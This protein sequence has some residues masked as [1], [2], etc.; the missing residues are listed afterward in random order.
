MAEPASWRNR[1]PGDLS[2]E[3]AEIRATP[4]ADAVAAAANASRDWGRRPLSHRTTLLSQAKEAIVAHEEELARGIALEMGKPIREARGEIGAVIAKFDLT[5]QDA[6]RWIRPESVTDGAHPARIHRR[7]RGPAAVIAPFNFPIHLGHGAALAH[8]AAGNPV[9][10]KPSP[11]AAAVAARYA[12]LMAGVLPPGVFTL[13]QG[14]AETGR[15]LCAHPT[16]RSVC[17]TGSA[18]AGRHLAR[19]LADDVSKD[20]ALELGGK[21]AAIVCADADL[22]LAAQAVADGLCLT[23]G[24]RCNATSRVLVERHASDAFL[25]ALVRALC[26]YVPGNPLSDTTKLGPLVTGAAL[27]RHRRLCERND[28]E[29]IL[30]GSAPGT[31]D[32]LRGH[33]VTPAVGRT[34][35]ALSD[36]DPACQEVFCPMLLVTPWESEAEA[37]TLNNQTPYGLTCSIFTR[38]RE[39]FE[40]LAE[41][42]EDANVYANLPTTF[43]PSTLPFGGWKNSGNRR[44]GGRGFIRFVT[45]EQAVQVARGSW[46]SP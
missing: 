41:A 9:L 17:F 43:S 35:T 2:L 34:L 12:D 11:L 30:K 24:Q 37:A 6:E 26:A 20:L 3:L 33:Y 31:A 14:G 8:L 38:S 21:N 28:I 5:F 19:E 16:V 7:P 22:A 23:A 40:S 29:W 27:E 36:S 44:P 42:V 18:T 39:R 46:E 45:D 13:V 10:F 32:G 4:V 1:S 15:T 25:D